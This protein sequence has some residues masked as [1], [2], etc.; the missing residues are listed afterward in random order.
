MFKNIDVKCL[1]PYPPK[2][3]HA[4]EIVRYYVDNYDDQ[5]AKEVFQI[6]QNGELIT[7]K[8]TFEK[9]KRGNIEKVE[10][11]LEDEIEEE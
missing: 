7:D 11:I 4:F 5:K 9:V 3:T 2:F 8:R 1:Q 10:P 6:L